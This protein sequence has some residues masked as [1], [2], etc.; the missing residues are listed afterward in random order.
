M[1]TGATTSRPENFSAVKFRGLHQNFDLPFVTGSLCVMTLPNSFS[2]DAPQ[3]RACASP[4]E[5][6]GHGAG[7]AP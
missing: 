4:K 1:H 5:R 3:A 6:N 2:D 7:R